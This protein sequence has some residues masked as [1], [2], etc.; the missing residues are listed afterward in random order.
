MWLP[1]SNPHKGGQRVV[2]A[3]HDEGCHFDLEPPEIPTFHY[4]T[5][6]FDR[7][8]PSEHL[9]PTHT[10]H[11]RVKK[12]V[13]LNTPSMCFYWSVLH[14]F[15]RFQPWLSYAQCSSRILES[16]R[17]LESKWAMT[18]PA[19]LCLGVQQTT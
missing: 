6:G 15:Q 1:L 13:L 9:N 19:L 11:T 10:L 16:Y 2:E 18:I 12:A 14:G 17:I 3:I 7:G 4:S 5:R 8:V